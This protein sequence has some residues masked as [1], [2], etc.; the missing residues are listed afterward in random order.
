MRGE[1]R[2]GKESFEE[3]SPGVV[4]ED[5]A[6]PA[7]ITEKEWPWEGEGELGEHSVL[8]VKCRKCFKEDG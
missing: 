3:W 2:R 6:G 5:E 7:V 8:K 1:K 4:G